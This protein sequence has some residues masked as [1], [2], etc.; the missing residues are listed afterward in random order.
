MLS[1]QQCAPRLIRQDRSLRARSNPAE[2]DQNQKD[3]NHDA[4]PA[5]TVVA[6]AVEWPAAEPAESPQQDDDQDDEQNSSNRHVIVSKCL[7]WLVARKS[8][9]LR[10]SL[11]IRQCEKSARSMMIGIGTP[12]S[13]GRPRQGLQ[14]MRRIVP[15][16][17]AI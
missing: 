9:F 4:Q 12:S 8:C 1:S 3:D 11:A 14:R 16:P 15:C 5:A 2:Q 10:R 17:D 13:Q 7:W 6:G